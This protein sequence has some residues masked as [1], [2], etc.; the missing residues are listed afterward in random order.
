LTIGFGKIDRHAPEVIL[1]L[2]PGGN[3]ARDLRRADD[4]AAVV[5]DR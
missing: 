5:T 2:P 1:E 3:V 4:A